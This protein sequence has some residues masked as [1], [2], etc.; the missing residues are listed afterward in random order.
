MDDFGGDRPASAAPRLADGRDAG[1]GALT[2]SVDRAGLVAVGPGRRPLDGAP[3]AEDGLVAGLG[4]EGERP[5]GVAPSSGVAP[6][7]DGGQP[8]EAALPPE[9]ERPP[10]DATLSPEITP[11]GAA[12]PPQITPLGDM[13]PP[14]GPEPEP[15]VGPGVAPE[16]AEPEPPMSSGV[17]PDRAVAVAPVT[18]P[19]PLAARAARTEARLAHLHLQARMLAL[20]RAELETLAAL[21]ALDVPALSDLAEVRWRTGDLVGAG[22]AAEAHLEAGGEEL[23]A[24]CVAAEA[25]TAMGRTAEARELAARVLARGRERV[26]ELFA[27]QARSAVWPRD[28]FSPGPLTAAPAAAGDGSTAVTPVASRLAAVASGDLA[29]VQAHIARGEMSG[30]GTRLALVLRDRPA[31]APA[32]LAVA[33][34][35][36]PL[37]P[38]GAEVASLHLAR[39]DAYRLMGRE[40]EAAEAFWQSSKA[41]HGAVNREETQ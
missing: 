23:V 3:D 20:A 2:P 9:G 29:D 35:A 10:E 37:A 1:S 26:D 30:T 33:D 15:P 40:T 13:A 27:G 5:P 22:Q 36:L 14:L 19:P 31:L 17:A 38:S 41:L 32:V 8:G 24:M 7:T 11:P 34:E 25:A 6:A 12:A 21:D 18:A 39:G 4:A 28:V 16:V